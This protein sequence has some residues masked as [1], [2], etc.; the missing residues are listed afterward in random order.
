MD[1]NNI[2]GDMRDY[3]VQK[4]PCLTCPFE[5][6]K[7]LKL[8]PASLAR[9]IEN[10]ATGEGQHICHTSNNTRVCRGGRNLQKQILFMRGLLPEPTDEAFE[11]AVDEANPRS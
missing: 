2:K 1:I 11:R 3:P 6:E 4:D 9:Y 8:A 10:L 5:G 7:P